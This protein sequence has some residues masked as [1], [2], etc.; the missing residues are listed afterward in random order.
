M[1]LRTP[2]ILVALAVVSCN[3]TDEAVV[4][5]AATPQAAVAEPAAAARPTA[6]L[7]LDERVRAAIEQL[8]E[9]NGWPSADEFD[10][11]FDVGVSPYRLVQCG[12]ATL[13]SAGET[14][15]TGPVMLGEVDGQWAVL[16]HAD[17]SNNQWALNGAWE[18]PQFD[19]AKPK[20]ES[21]ENA[22][23][24]HA[25]TVET[26]RAT[27]MPFSTFV[28]ASVLTTPDE[29]TFVPA[30]ITEYDD[31]RI[32]ALRE[33]KEWDEAQ[34]QKLIELGPP[35]GDRAWSNALSWATGND[36]LDLAYEIH[37]RY[38][39]MGRC[40]RDSRPQSTKQTFAKVCDELS[41]PRCFLSLSTELLGYRHSRRSD[42]WIGGKPVSYKSPI[43]D[44][45]S[46]LD[47]ELFLLGLLVDYPGTDRNENAGISPRFFAL[48]QDNGQHTKSLDATLVRWLQNPDTDAW[49]RHR[50]A[51]A[52]FFMRSFF[53]QSI[54]QRKHAKDITELAGVPAV[55]VAQLTNVVN[56][57]D[58]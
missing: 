40:S 39:P 11:R 23:E 35:S 47:T 19:P 12:A 25:P 49:N 42:M 50:F 58:D 24:C 33:I 14:H 13:T 29:P 7:G 3:I 5:D 41:R 4:D 28:Y 17:Q 16:A 9:D 48:A 43:A 34:I 31:E 18:A 26:V 1:R 8:P 45:P 55:T 53:D 57:E 10:T 22:L 54:D 2:T 38:R 44:L 6:L 32:T 46:D 36:R 37:R 30:K 51:V 56:H 15:E 21:G 27:P 20:F 52:L